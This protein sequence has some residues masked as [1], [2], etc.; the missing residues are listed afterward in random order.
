MDV[1]YVWLVLIFSLFVGELGF[2]YDFF[3]I[4]KMN[5]RNIIFYMI[6]FMLV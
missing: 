5:K 1:L 4:Y 2:L 6:L 3:K